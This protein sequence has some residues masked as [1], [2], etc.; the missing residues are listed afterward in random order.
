MAGRTTSICMPARP[1]LVLVSH[2]QYQCHLMAVSAEP[3]EPQS[4]I[5]S[6]ET[7]PAATFH[8]AERHAQSVSNHHA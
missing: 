7:L 4:R 1:A 3:S 5:V 2:L 6:W 8:S